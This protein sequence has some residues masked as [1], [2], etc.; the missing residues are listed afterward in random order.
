[1][2]EYLKENWS[3]ILTILFLLV[4]GILLLINPV[5]YA[6]AI[7]KIAGGL[8]ALLGI[9]D[10]VKYFKA[11]PEVAAK[12]SAFFSGVIMI[13][14][15]IIFLVRGD[16][17]MET[18][19]ILAVVYG[20]FQIV[21][22]YSKLQKAVDALRLK[23]PLWWLKAICAGISLLFG[24]IIVFNPDM[25]WIGIWVFTGIT[26]IIEAVLDTISLVARGKQAK[27]KVK[28]QEQPAAQA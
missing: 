18:F 8:L 26:M 7:L 22:G 9:Y 17:L 13:T 5:L 3:T 6:I 27:A 14:V 16:T 12:G 4:V 10:L 11:P 21:L 23:M 20:A 25:T 19:P 1:M 24:Y 15:G 28:A 2:K